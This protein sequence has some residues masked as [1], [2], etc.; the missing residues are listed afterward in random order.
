MQA[1]PLWLH[2]GG[3]GGGWM[4]GY[5]LSHG[6]LPYAVLKCWSL[7]ANLPS[8]WG[9]GAA[10]R[11]RLSA[12]NGLRALSLLGIIL[13]HT[14]TYMLE[15]GF[16]NSGSV[17]PPDG[18]FSN[19]AFQIVPAAGF[20]VD[21]FLLLSGFLAAHTL[22]KHMAARAAA[23]RNGSGGS[24]GSGGGDG[25]GFGLSLRSTAFFIFHRL[26]RLL[27]SYGVVLAAY[28][29]IVPY[30]GSGPFWWTV[31]QAAGRCQQW[32]WTNLAFIN[33][34]V[35]ATNT[36]SSS[37]APWTFYLAVDM[38]L[39]LIAPL[40]IVLHALAPLIGV[41]LI[42]AMAIISIV[43]AAVVVARDG[44]SLRINLDTATV[45]A[46]YADEVFT[47]PWMRGTPFII[48]ILVAIA[49][50]HVQQR[51]AEHTASTA[52]R[53]NIVGIET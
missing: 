45:D 1:G 2:V 4:S 20:A 14:L 36:Y 30:L 27:P 18:A 11:G 9:L 21:T 6:W 46:A 33:N 3:G 31:T 51:R 24:D 48:G 13:G 44:L 42:V 12:V 43:A 17:L 50:H 15:I 5:R 19:W 23:A 49:W 35:P 25:G 7:L 38:Q 10:R 41:A 40:L 52:P 8:V 47:K 39:H 53:R 26:L 28:T 16:V 29:V 32:A 37:C 22:R 34:L